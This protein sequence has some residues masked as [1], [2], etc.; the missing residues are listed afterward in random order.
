M[1]SRPQ[2]VGILATEIYFPSQVRVSCLSGVGSKQSLFSHSGSVSS[3]QPLNRL[4]AWPLESTP[5]GWD[6]PK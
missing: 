5:L 3:N 2:N 6:R 4:M 1:L